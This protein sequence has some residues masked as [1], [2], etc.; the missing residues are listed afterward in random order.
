MYYIRGNITNTGKQKDIIGIMW[1]V[2]TQ[3]RKTKVHKQWMKCVLMRFLF[4][5]QIKSKAHYVYHAAMD[6]L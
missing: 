1:N 2:L 4:K 3:Q 5:C 6:W